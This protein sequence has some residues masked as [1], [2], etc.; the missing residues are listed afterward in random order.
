MPDDN[1]QKELFLARA[2]LKIVQ[3][4]IDEA[5]DEEPKGCVII[6]KPTGKSAISEEAR[7]SA[8]D[9]FLNAMTSLADVIGCSQQDVHA[10]F[11][12]PSCNQ[13]FLPKFP[14]W[15][16]NHNFYYQKP[17]LIADKE[18][19]TYIVYWDKVD[20]YWYYGLRKP[21]GSDISG[22][23]KSYFMEDALEA[24]AKDIAIIQQQYLKGDTADEDTNKE[25]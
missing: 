21:R 2:D 13:R 3:F 18:I 11:S 20:C 19:G 7:Y 23:G 15:E 5:V 16:S 8:Y 1:E 9:N 22:G 14:D 25:D 6:H 12:C 17:V 24:A 10:L 4:Y